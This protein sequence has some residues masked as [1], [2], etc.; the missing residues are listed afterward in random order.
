MTVQTLE[1]PVI[2]PRIAPA[3]LA[4]L[5]DHVPKLPGKNINPD[6][7]HLDFVD[8][9]RGLAV[10]G[11]I[12]VHC[13]DFI[14]PLPGG[15]VKAIA[16]RGGLGVPLFYLASAFTLF[17]SMEQRRSKD[18][19]PV[20]AF[21][22]RRFFRIAPLFYI[23]IPLSVLMDGTAPW[24]EAPYGTTWW[25]IA[26]SYLFLHGWHPETTNGV[27]PGGWS[28]G[29]EM[30]FYLMLP[31]LFVWITSLRRAVIFFVAALVIRFIAD[32]VASPLVYAAYPADKRYIAEMFMTLWLPAQ[33][34]TFAA[35]IIFYFVF[36]TV[37]AAQRTPKWGYACLLAVVAT[38]PLGI[39]GGRIAADLVIFLFAL[40][41]ALHPARWIVNPV[42]RYL[43]KVSY[44]MYL[45]NFAAIGAGLWV[46]DRLP[47]TSNVTVRLAVL[48]LLTTLADVALATVAFHLVEEP[49]RKLGKLL[50]DRLQRR[51]P[52]DGRSACPH[53]GPDVL[54]A[55]QKA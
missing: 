13:K 39:I 25:H 49:G 20:L 5:Y 17:L 55:S 18:S 23:M 37:R 2:A 21:F 41:L 10:L 1:A 52:V 30:T 15:V 40:A 24:Y 44:G 27:V 11:V 22:L 29:V 45:L 31:F 7:V 38:A 28:I 53:N 4:P 47:L 35:G 32:A 50:I 48:V 12:L 8:T 19:R 34:H 43:G 54:R 6:I 3:E 14:G 46:M 26:G 42:T 9:L 51:G 33:L 36:K 16:T